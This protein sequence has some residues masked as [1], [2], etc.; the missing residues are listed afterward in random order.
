[1]AKYGK[2]YTFENA[3]EA[4]HLIGKKVAYSNIYLGE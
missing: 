3:E 2:I 4:R 1:M